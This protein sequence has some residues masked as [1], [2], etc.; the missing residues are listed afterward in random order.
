MPPLVAFAGGGTGGHLY[1]AIAVAHALRRRVPNL[2]ILFLATDRPIDRQ[3]LGQVDCEFAAQALPRLSRLPWHWP[4]MILALRGAIREV[5]ARF[6]ADPPLAVIGTGGSASVPAVRTARQMNIPTALLNPDALPGRANRYLARLADFVFVQWEETR[7]HLRFHTEVRALGCP[8]RE[9]FHSSDAE[10]GRRRFQLHAARKTIL[11][12]G[13]SQGARTINQA[14]VGN[15]DFLATLEDW[16][17]LHL[18]GERDFDSVQAAYRKAGLEAKVLR[19]TDHMAFCVAAADLVIS[20]AGASTLAELTALGRASILMPYPFHRDQHQVAN[21]Q[22]LVRRGAAR[23]V[24]DRKDAAANAAAL[25]EALEELTA[26][27]EV[28][29]AMAAAARKMGATDAASR[30][31]DTIL[32]MRGHVSIAPPESLEVTCGTTR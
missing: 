22:C 1:P 25:R 7:E 9:G 29:E 13:A 24:V 17:I 27:D 5:R 28:R 11:I 30:I 12:T 2:H 16:Q 32:S 6:E 23:L 21:A 19:F 15:L 31:A 20:R 10:E 26:Q 14:A 8:I 18:T 4:S 3:I